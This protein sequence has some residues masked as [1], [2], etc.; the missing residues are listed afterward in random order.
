MRALLETL[1]EVC[2]RA[3]LREKVVVVPSLAI[4]HQIGDALARGG[5]PWINLRFETTRTIADAVTGFALQA[6]GWKVLSRAQALA[7][8]ERACDSAL[9]GSSYFAEL[10]GKPGLYRAI[11]RSIDDLRHAGL[12]TLPA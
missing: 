4:G 2:G 10:A 6:E 7:V 11:Q 12:E 9:D 5:T 8:L 3:P 1:R